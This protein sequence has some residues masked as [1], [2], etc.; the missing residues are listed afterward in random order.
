MGNQ[1]FQRSRR[2]AREAGEDEA[3]EAL[4]SGDAAR[5]RM[6]RSCLDAAEPEA[7][8][9][10]EQGGGDGGEGAEEAFGVAGVLVEASRCGGSLEEGGEAAVEPCGEVAVGVEQRYIVCGNAE[11]GNGNEAH[12][13]PVADKERGSDGERVGEMRG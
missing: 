5:E 13:S 11:A 9:G 3:D 1:R 2:R 8:D 4:S 12:E 6:A 7:G 10:A